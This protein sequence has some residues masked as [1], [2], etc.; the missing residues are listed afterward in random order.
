MAPRY[1]ILGGSSERAD[2]KSWSG[3]RMCGTH[4]ENHCATLV[5]N[6][7]RARLT[8]SATVRDNTINI[9][10]RLGSLNTAAKPSGAVTTRIIHLIIVFL[11]S[12]RGSSEEKKPGL[13]FS[14]FQPSFSR[15]GRGVSAEFCWMSAA[16]TL[17]LEFQPTEF[18]PS[19]SRVSAHRFPTRP[20]FQRV[21]AEFQPTGGGS[22][23]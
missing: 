13:S 7:L 3:C 23:S 17:F 18:Q 14:E 16:K 9:D 22:F 12:P 10:S 5:P 1:R 11:R 4:F 15:P 6:L 20:E 2:R 21:S 8:T 19:F